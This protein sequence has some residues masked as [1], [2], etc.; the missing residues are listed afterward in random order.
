[1]PKY[2]VFCGQGCSIV[3]QGCNRVEQLFAGLEFSPHLCS[4]KQKQEHWSVEKKDWVLQK[5]KYCV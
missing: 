2:V 1:L 5:R 4:V 3:E